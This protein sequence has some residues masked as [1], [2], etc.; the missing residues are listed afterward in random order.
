MVP[1]RHHD[2]GLSNVTALAD[3]EIE[4]KEL[5]HNLEL[6]LIASTAGLPPAPCPDA[7]A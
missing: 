1:Q 5:L 6:L 7:P 2:L 3:D 4:S